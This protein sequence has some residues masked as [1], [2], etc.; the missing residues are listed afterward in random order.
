MELMIREAARIDIPS[1]L[2]LLYELERPKP[3]DKFGVESFRN[4]IDEYFLDSQKTIIVSEQGK[5]I[6]G[7]VSII[8]LKR[9]NQFKSEMYIPELI[10]TE[11]FR[12]FGTGKKLMQHCNDLAKQNNCYRIRLESG[13]QRNNAHE[14]YKNIG[15]EQSALS[16]TKHIV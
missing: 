7:F 11:R 1:I 3:L 6:T 14:F 16:F 13:N 2:N 5:E 9:L 8:Y 4:K 15:F 12:Q 10:V